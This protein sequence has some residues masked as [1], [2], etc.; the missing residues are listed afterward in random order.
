MYQRLSNYTVAR[1]NYSKKLVNTTDNFKYYFVNFMFVYIKHCEIFKK[2]NT[3]SQN[4]RITLYGLIL[5][6]L[7]INF[8]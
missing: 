2:R 8:K 4:I 3:S 1:K 6:Q 7:F 5:K